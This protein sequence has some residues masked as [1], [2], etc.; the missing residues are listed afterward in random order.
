MKRLAALLLIVPIAA[1]STGIEKTDGKEITIGYYNVWDSPTSLR[2][3][4]DA[5]CAK[6]GRIAEHQETTVD[7]GLIDFASDS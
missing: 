5:E 4:A 2:P 6:S 1:C 3:V 7:D